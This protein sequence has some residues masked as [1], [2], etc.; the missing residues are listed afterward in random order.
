MVDPSSVIQVP[1]LT[2][3]L[4]KLLPIV[5]LVI[6]IYDG[7]NLARTAYG[8]DRDADDVARVAARA[9]S[10]TKDVNAAYNAA[11][12]SLKDG[13]TIPQNSFAVDEFGTVTLEVSRGKDTLLIGKVKRE[14][15]TF[16]VE[17]SAGRPS[18]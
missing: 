2:M 17:G 6:V 18:T 3:R 16:T 10:S 13:D 1:A 12:A 11:V 5:L 14:W 4:L 15:E 9:Y 8:V 7:A